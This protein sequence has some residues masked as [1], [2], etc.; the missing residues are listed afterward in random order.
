M[1]RQYDY[2]YRIPD[3]QV[4][5]YDHDDKR[6]LLLHHYKGPSGRE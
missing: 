6:S 3:I 1:A 2:N 5:D 4:V